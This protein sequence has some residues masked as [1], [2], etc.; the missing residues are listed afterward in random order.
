MIWVSR[1]ISVP[2]KSLGTFYEAGEGKAAEFNNQNSK[3]K[4]QHCASA[5]FKLELVISIVNYKI[6]YVKWHMN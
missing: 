1:G 2:K 6:T 5:V 3:V 4:C